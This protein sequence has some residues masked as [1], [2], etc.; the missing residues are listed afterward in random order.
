MRAM[1]RFGVIGSAVVAMVLAG[2]VT[3]S[4]AGC[5]CEKPPP[6][7][8]PLRPPF[9]SPGSNVTLIADGL[10]VGESY[11]ATFYGW[12]GDGPTGEEATADGVAVSK[13]DFADGVVKTQVVVAVPEMD[14]GPAA[15]VLTPLEGGEELLEVPADDFTVL[16][17]ELA[18]PDAKGH[19]IAR[20]YRAAVSMDGTVYLPLDITGVTD[21]M[22]FAGRAGG[23]RLTYG[24]D[25]IVI[26]NTQGVTMQL[27]DPDMVGLYTIDDAADADAQGDPDNKEW[28]PSGRSFR[29]TYDRHEFETYRELHEDDP[30][31]AHDPDDADWHV[32]GT[33]HYDHDHLVLAIQGAIDGEIVPEP[34]VTSPF[35]FRVKRTPANGMGAAE[36]TDVEWADDCEAEPAPEPVP[37]AAPTCGETPFAGC[38]SSVSAGRSKLQ[39]EDRDDDTRDAF[40]WRWTYGQ[41]TALGN[42]GDPSTAEGLVVCLYDESGETPVLLFEAGAPPN[43]GC[44]TLGRLPCWIRNGTPEKPRGFTYRNRQGLPDGIGEVSLKPGRDRRA[45]VVVGGRGEHLE[46]PALP[47]DVPVRAQL[48]S[49]TGQ[50]WE[51]EFAAEGVRKNTAETFKAKSE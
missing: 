18:L 29:M 16:Q 9:A 49:A 11:R 14:A 21:R 45:Q 17:A 15:V 13:R 32:N 40:V 23:Y 50:C 34:G 51:S 24:A 37:P 20:C 22:I 25:D 12:D 36:N 33:R 7:V 4:D 47:L 38:R 27:L 5:G 1:R 39:I 6:P 2:T 8:A 41:D 28:G 10:V 26:Y 35:T 43:E 3:R 31:Y 44:D 19:T 30:D 42:F 46:L 48:Q